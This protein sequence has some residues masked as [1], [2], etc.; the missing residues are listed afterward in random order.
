MILFLMGTAKVQHGD[1]NMVFIP[2]VRTITNGT[3]TTTNA[4]YTVATLDFGTSVSY[5]MISHAIPSTLRA[6]SVTL[7]CT[8]TDTSAA[9]IDV[10]P[11]GYGTLAGIIGT[12][13]ISDSGSVEIVA[14]IPGG[15]GNIV[16]GLTIKV[17][18][19]AVGDKIGVIYVTVDQPA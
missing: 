6:K 11:N 18:L 19:R 14:D 17:T 3:L 7:R 4:G 13:T 1:R 5:Y 15:Y 9:D 12:G 2:T 10:Y 8:K 16:A